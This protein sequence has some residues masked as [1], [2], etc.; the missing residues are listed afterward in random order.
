M[1]IAKPKHTV[2]M[3]DILVGIPIPTLLAIVSYWSV[4]WFLMIWVG[5]L[6]II[7]V[8]RQI[9]TMLV[10]DASNYGL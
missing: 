10:F 8:S 1:A 4:V 2:G 7:P 6:V 9:G 5:L 3:V